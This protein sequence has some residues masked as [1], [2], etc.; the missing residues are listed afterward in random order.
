[1]VKHGCLLSFIAEDLDSITSSEQPSMIPTPDQPASL[2][3]QGL[4][5]LEFSENEGPG[6][7]TETEAPL[8]QPIELQSLHAEEHKKAMTSSYENVYTGVPLEP[9]VN[10]MSV[11]ASEIDIGDRFDTKQSESKLQ[12]G[13]SSSYEKL[14]EKAAELS[15]EEGECKSESTPLTA[16]SSA[17]IDVRSSFASTVLPS[18]S[19]TSNSS[20]VYITVESGLDKLACSGDEPDIGL[21]RISGSGGH[22]GHASRVKVDLSERSAS[23]DTEDHLSEGPKPISRPVSSP[24]VS[25]QVDAAIHLDKC[26]KG[27][28]YPIAFVS[29]CFLLFLRIGH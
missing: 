20:P 14:Y 25:F 17:V 27:R 10:R 29:H 24:D 12:S 23:C 15:E 6:Q 18:H 8:P 13:L 21:A 19:V 3:T 26:D 22:V 1:M 4:S 7:N 28:S 11:D 5:S 16:A 2:N 9:E